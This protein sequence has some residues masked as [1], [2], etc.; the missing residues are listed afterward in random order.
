MCIELNPS[1]A[2]A[3]FLKS[4]RTNDL[5]KTSKSYYVGMHWIKKVSKMRIHM[6]GFKSF[7]M[8][9]LHHFVLGKLATS[10][11]RVKLGLKC[12]SYFIPGVYSWHYKQACWVLYRYEEG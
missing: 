3:T 1:N 7:F 2:E 6:P 5:R 11:I 12:C 9:F 4:T 8:F 10:S